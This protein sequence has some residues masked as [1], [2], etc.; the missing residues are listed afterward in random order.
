[1]TTDRQ[2]AFD[3]VLGTIPFTGQVLSEV[4]NFWFDATSD[5]VPNHLLETPDPNVVA[6]A[7]RYIA[8]A[9]EITRRPF[10]PTPATA[11]ERVLAL[12]SR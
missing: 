11:S 10:E 4:A 9:D 7:S 3:R 2:S 6:T 5:I 1:M 8:L 12:L